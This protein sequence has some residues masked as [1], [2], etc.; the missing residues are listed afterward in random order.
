MVLT[1]DSGESSETAP[2][3]LERIW[4][5]PV[6]SLDGVQVTGAQ[7]S[8]AGSLLHDR[9]FALFDGDDRR[10]NA[11]RHDRIHSIRARFDPQD[12]LSAVFRAPDK[13]ELSVHLDRAEDVQKAAAWLSDW[14]DFS[15][16]IRR[17]P[18]SGF[19]DD[20]KR[21]G[22]TIVSRA[23]LE[24]ASSWLPPLSADELAE[25]FRANLEVARVPAFWEDRLLSAGG[26]PFRVGDVEM[27]GLNPCARC[28]VP[29]RDPRTGALYARFSQTLT[30]R[31]EE[32]LPDWADPR[33]FSH[34]Y[35]I[36]T[37]TSIDAAQA[38]RLIRV[39]DPVVLSY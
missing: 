17:A 35:R 5:Y 24:S 31:R 19:P 20:S 27:L 1:N 8:P 29:T 7:I 37:N 38:G 25:R 13:A 23:S 32:T 28:V 3:V 12:P 14:F 9:E 4:L 39:G 15:V 10:V 34:Y 11:K 18:D 2:G 36:S 6:K 22:P 16:E 30:K 26:V 21:P 33:L